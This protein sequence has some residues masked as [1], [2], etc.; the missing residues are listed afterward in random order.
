MSFY[1]YILSRTM[2]YWLNIDISTRIAKL[3]KETCIYCKPYDKHTKGINKMN[4]GGGWFKY[5]SPQEVKKLYQDLDL[6]IFWQ[7]CK[8]CKPE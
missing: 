1:I 6:K 8:I 5:E 2:G 4:S 7:P 3:H